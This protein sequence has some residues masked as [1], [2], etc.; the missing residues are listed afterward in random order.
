MWNSNKSLIATSICTKVTIGIVIM[1]ILTAPLMVKGYVS[2]ASK[3]PYVIRPLVA[4]VYACAV[5]GLAAMIALNKLLKNIRKKEVFTEKNVKLLRLLSWCSFAVS[6]I[7]FVSGFYYLMFLL[8]AF[9]AAF[10]GLILRVV[11]NVIEQAVMI[12]NENDFTI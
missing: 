2:Y 7:L 12:K 10:F 6:G 11:K 4:T 9:A 5:P 1:I 8:I 3:D